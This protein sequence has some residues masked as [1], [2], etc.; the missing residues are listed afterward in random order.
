MDSFPIKV[1]GELVASGLVPVTDIAGEDEED[2]VLLREMSEEAKNYISS[3]SWCGAILESY[4][5]GGVGKIFAV[6]FFHIRPSRPTVDSW[7]WIVVGEI[8]PAYL[9][10]E[11]C[12][13]PF[14]VFWTYIDG[15]S[16]WVEL[17]DKERPGQMK[18]AFPQ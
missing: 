1:T 15:M 18:R 16:R 5:G 2:T 11:D 9:P 17:R 12:Q 6:F 14:E 13:S 8:P 3:F 10:F 7:I 4:F